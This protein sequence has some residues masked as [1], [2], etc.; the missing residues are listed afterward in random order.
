ML[1]FDNKSEFQVIIDLP[2][3]ATLEETSAVASEMGDYLKTVNEVVD[4]EIYVGTA[5]PFNFNG[6][7]RHYY[8]RQGTYVADIQV[9]LVA[10]NIGKPRVMTSPRGGPALKAS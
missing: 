9:N 5:A 2:E 8:L 10:R 4:Y 6:L 7:V 3:K 1:P